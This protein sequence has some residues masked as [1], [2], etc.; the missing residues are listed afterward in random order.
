RAR[1]VESEPIA[2]ALAV[3]DVVLESVAVDQLQRAATPVLRDAR[4]EVHHSRDAI[5]SHR[6]RQVH[7][8]ASAVVVRG[9]AL[10]GGDRDA[11]IVAPGLPD[12]PLHRTIIT[13]RR[14]WVLTAVHAVQDRAVHRV[15]S[16]A[17]LDDVL[18]RGDPGNAIVR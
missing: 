18:T 4:G 10:S 11:G 17:F 16:V 8:L 3:L 12:H 7:R 1:A 5:G 15:A 9:V 2:D 14:E 6:V 13:E